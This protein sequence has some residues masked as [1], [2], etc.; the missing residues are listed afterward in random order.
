MTFKELKKRVSFE[1]TQEQ[2]ILLEKL[3]N[4]PFWIWNIELH[5]QEGIRTDGNSTSDGK[6]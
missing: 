5:K 4:K 6:G 1:I 3:Q 2:S